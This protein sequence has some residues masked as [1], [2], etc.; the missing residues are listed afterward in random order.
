MSAPE[1]TREFDPEFFQFL[2]DVKEHND[3]EWFAAN[4]ARYEAEVLEPALAFIEDFGYRLQEI[5]PH[6]RADPRRVGGSLFRIYRDTRFAKDKTPFKTHTGMHFRHVAPKDVHAPGYYLHLGP[7]DVF[8][9]GGIWRPDTRTRNRIRDAIAADPDGWREA[10]QTSPF[11]DRLT[12][13]GEQQKRVPPAFPA[14][15]E[16][17]DDL[18]R[19]GWVGSV[20]LSETVAT[21]PG[22]LDEYTRICEAG[23]PLLRFLCRALDLEF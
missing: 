10:T 22:F 2:S 4:K 12:L 19:N 18:R 17:A 8:A 7:G 9:G 14:D 5:S 20:T 11:T 1:V 23:A 21:T 3:R 15:H 6:M 16:H 13:G